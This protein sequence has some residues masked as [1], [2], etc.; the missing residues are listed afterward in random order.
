M[1]FSALEALQA[2]GAGRSMAQQDRQQTRAQQDQQRQDDERAGLSKAYDPATGTIDPAR[3]RAAYAGAGDIGG[4]LA[5][6]QHMTE[7]HGREFTQYREAMMAAPALLANVRDEAGYQ[8]ALAQAQSAGLPVQH[9][10]PHYDPQWVQ[11]IVHQGTLLQQAQHYQPPSAVQ[12]QLESAGIHPGTPEYRTA[13]MQHLSA[14]RIMMVDGVPTLVSGD[15]GAGGGG[16][17]APDLPHVTTQEE[18]AR[19]AP[20]SQFIGPDNQVHTVPGGPTPQA[21]GGFSGGGVW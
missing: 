20:G 19:L 5:F 8:A 9:A 1:A 18:A 12:Q 2:F 14:P 3:A 16:G 11:N 4:A 7:T 15:A 13:I 10:P 17:T 21:S 6:D